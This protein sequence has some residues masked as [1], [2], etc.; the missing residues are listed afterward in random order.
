MTFSAQLAEVRFGYGRSP[1]IP[2]PAS[3]AAMLDGL[4]GPDEMA[5][6]FP[7]IGFD[8]FQPIAREARELHLALR[9]VRGS[10]DEEAARQKVNAHMRDTGAAR[11]GWYGQTL[12][13]AV[14]SQTA[15]RERLVAFWADHFTAA[16]KGG[17]MRYATSPY[18]ED[19]I[20]PHVAG[21]FGDMLVAAVTHPLMLHYL[22]QNQSKGPGSRFA[23]RHPDRK[24][25]LNENL[26]REILELHTLGVDG[27]YD[28]QDVRQLAELLTGL[29]FDFTKGGHFWPGIAEPG[30]ETVLGKAYGGDPA[31]IEHV[32]AALR[33]IAVH[34]ATARHIAWK[35]AV[36]FVSDEPPEDLVA[37][38][39]ARYGETGGNLLAVYGA[40]LDHPA[41][42]SPERVNVRPADAYVASAARALAVPP[43]R[44]T[45][46]KRHFI[47]GH[48][49]AP[50]ALMGLS[51]QRPAGPDGLPEED[52]SWVTPQ[53]VSARLRWAISVPQRLVPALP[54]PVALAELTLGP[55]VPPAVLFAARAAESR[56][57]A[58]GLVLASPAFQRC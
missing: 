39:A 57:E 27:P 3:V 49:I 8:G 53:S 14:H 4:V 47:F 21:D 40:L 32:H 1:D 30:A 17:V 48:F 5:L 24:A 18:V 37:Q 45:D 56:A 55:D 38:V 7:I 50:L 34:P 22:D 52:I 28:Q 10:E 13:R 31:R 11:L 9:E 35:L 44:I 46:R 19:A 6:R 33:D 51:W 29:R 16:G 41:S 42:W 15:F 23:R 26:A 25:G 43:D 12:L 36:H 2:P 58:V 54:D 20:R